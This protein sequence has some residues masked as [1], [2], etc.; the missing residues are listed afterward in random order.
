MVL[1]SPYDR[2]KKFIMRIAEEKASMMPTF[3]VSGAISLISSQIEDK[4][5][6]DISKINPC[7]YASL[8]NIPSM[9]I[10][11]DKDE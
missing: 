3:V 8:I 2:L 5:G 1:D 4:T 6:V 7:E 11:G 9:W 10:I